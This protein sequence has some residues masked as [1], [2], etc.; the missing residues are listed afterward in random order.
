MNQKTGTIANFLA[1]IILLTM[2]FIYLISSSF[3]PYHSEAVTMEWHELE[4]SM[5][6]LILALM[7]AVSGGFI[8]AS[9]VIIVLQIKF[10]QSKLSWIPWLILVSGLIVSFASVYATL[11]IRFNTPGEAP[12][13]LAL[14]G[15]IILI[16]GFIF[17]KKALKQANVML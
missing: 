14:V 9:V 8:A 15:S 3:M 13:T 12:T 11:I 7:R 5:Q 6:S 17:N 1:A 16:I 2:G 4:S 10:Y